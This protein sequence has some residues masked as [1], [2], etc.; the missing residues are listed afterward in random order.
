VVCD[1]RARGRRQPPT[2]DALQA[3]PAPSVPCPT[4]LRDELRHR[5]AALPDVERLLLLGFHRDE[6]S[7]KQLADRHQLPVNTVKSHLHRA[8]RRLADGAS[9]QGGNP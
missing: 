8:R 2:S 5:L 3:A 9:D 6:L 7:L 4:E 1:H